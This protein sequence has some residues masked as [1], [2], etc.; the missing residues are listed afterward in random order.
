MNISQLRKQ[1]K[2]LIARG[3]ADYQRRVGDPVDRAVTVSHKTG[4]VIESLSIRRRSVERERFHRTYG[5]AR[6]LLLKH[7]YEK[8][9]DAKVQALYAELIPDSDELKAKKRGLLKDLRSRDEAKRLA[10]AKECSK[11]ARGIGNIGWDNWPKSPFVIE[12][13]LT[14]LSKEKSLDVAENL[15]IALGGMYERYYADCRIPPA[16]FAY[17]ES[18]E[19]Q[20]QQ[21]ALQWTCRIRDRAKWPQIIEILA[22]NP[23]TPI[24]RAALW[25][26]H[27][28]VPGKLHSR[29][30]VT[31]K[32]KL[33][34]ILLEIAGRKLGANVT[35]D[36][37]EA[38]LNNVD[39]RTQ[40]DYR[41]ALHDQKRLLK[42]LA[43][44]AERHNGKGSDRFQYL[45][46]NLF[47]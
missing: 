14:A 43:K 9:Q 18:D 15:I 41:A 42:S 1:A 6:D 20:L 32:R 24:L 8:S 44:H 19:R 46:A 16:L 47:T 13:I 17:F 23:T 34:P 12:S 31:V 38:I 25:H 2:A 7:G 28:C 22:S 33:L 27:T 10:A 35:S 45:Q 4:E 39:E 5:E 29:T 26:L 11:V 40:A 21:A 30:P 36:L 3:A 37:Y